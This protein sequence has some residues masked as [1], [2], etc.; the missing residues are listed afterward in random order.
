[1][2]AEIPPSHLLKYTFYVLLLVGV[3]AIAYCGL[4]FLWKIVLCVLWIFYLLYLKKQY[5][6]TQFY[7]TDLNHPLFISIFLLV[8]YPKPSG[9]RVGTQ[10]RASKV[11][12]RVH[13]G[14]DDGESNDPE[15]LREKGI[16]SP[17]IIWVDQTS[18]ENW[19][20]WIFKAKSALKITKL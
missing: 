19:C 10:P 14:S 12:E 8:L 3:G 5:T 11:Y 7:I 1:V 18:K 13:E 6:T 2:I 20:E 4:H 17:I 16:D 9:F 15:N